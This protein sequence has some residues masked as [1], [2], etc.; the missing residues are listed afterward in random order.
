MPVV[1]VDERYSSV[2]AARQLGDAGVFGAKRKAVIDQQAAVL[3]LQ[4]W[5]DHPE[6]AE[7]LR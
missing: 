3:I 4:S 2:D 7:G 1:W 6:L 5:L